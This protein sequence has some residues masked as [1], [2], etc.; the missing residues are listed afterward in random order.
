MPTPCTLNSGRAR[1]K[2]K[3][4]VKNNKKKKQLLA[5]HEQ[6]GQGRVKTNTAKPDKHNETAVGS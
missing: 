2:K 1:L 5:I 3:K 6:V 4:K